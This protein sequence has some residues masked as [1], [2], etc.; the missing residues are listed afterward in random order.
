MTNNQL[1]CKKKKDNTP[2]T[3]EMNINFMQEDSP[4]ILLLLT[5]QRSGCRSIN[6]KFMGLSLLYRP[7]KHI[8]TPQERDWL[9]WHGKS[10]ERRDH[11]WA[12][13]TMMLYENDARNNEQ[14]W[15]R[16]FIVLAR[17]GKCIAYHRLINWKIRE[18]YVLN[19]S[20]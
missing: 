16:V 7:Q 10:K 19:G 8:V 4:T 5:A 18:F 3:H 9:F 6:Q 13:P 2:M 14:W 20:F 1:Q 15:V 12:L 17:W 11:H